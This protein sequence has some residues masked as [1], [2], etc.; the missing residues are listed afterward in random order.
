MAI[1]TLIKKRVFKFLISQNTDG[2][3]LKSGIPFSE[4]A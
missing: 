4:I 2:L 3:H 1:K